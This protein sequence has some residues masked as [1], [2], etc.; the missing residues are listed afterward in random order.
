MKQFLYTTIL[1][2]FLF[3]M[4]CKSTEK[5]EKPDFKQLPSSYTR[6]N[7]SIN[8]SMLS[9]KQFFNDADLIVLLDIAVRNN[10]DEFMAMQKMKA[11]EARVNFWNNKM[12][13]DL[14][15]VASGSQRKFGMYTM[16]GAGNASTEILPGRIVPVNLPDYYLGLQSSWEIDMWGKLKNRKRSAVARYLSTIEGKNLVMTNLIAGI[17]TTYY[18]LLALDFQ[19]DIIK[20]TIKLQENALKIVKIQKQSAQTNDLAVKQFE[21]QL[22]NSKSLEIEILQQITESENLIN[23]YCG[24]FPQVVVR[25]KST[26]MNSLPQQI[27]TGIPSDLLKNRPDIRQAE[28]EMITSKADVKAA[29]AAFYP[30][31]VINGGIGFQAFKPDLLFTSPQSAIYNLVGTL[32]APLI[33]RNAIKAEFKAA[34]ALQISTMYNYQKAIINAYVEVYN[35]MVRVDNLQKIYNYKSQEVDVFTKAIESSSALFR[36]GNASYLEVLMTHKNVL[37]SRLELV[38]ARKKQYQ[39]VVSIYKAL[40]GGWR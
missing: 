26:F 14:N 17:A 1:I 20:E 35:E 2:S 19:L 25:N 9:W 40:G 23:F 8:I 39:S 16:D 10:P 22:L 34:N 13:P 24:R 3:L 12:L 7:D 30:S 6:P 32:V 38:T 21:A 31:F 29:K 11:A 28:L 27:Q 4:A 18:E 15:A 33:N 37:V 36:T 5:M